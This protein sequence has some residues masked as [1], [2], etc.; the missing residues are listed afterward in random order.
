MY[1]CSPP[2]PS[3]HCFY[4][5]ATASIHVP[6]F[7]NPITSQVFPLLGGSL[8]LALSPLTVVSPSCTF[9]H[10]KNCFFPPNESRTAQATVTP[11]VLLEIFGKNMHRLRPARGLVVLLKVTVDLVAVSFLRLFLC[12]SF[13]PLCF[14]IRCI[15]LHRA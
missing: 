15:F 13:S 12:R 6:V 4:T 5:I 10:K 3:Q 8:W 14:V 1:L 9:L 11:D 7:Q 2:P